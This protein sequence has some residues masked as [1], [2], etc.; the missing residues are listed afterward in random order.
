ML[1][2]SKQLL[3]LTQS[4]HLRPDALARRQLILGKLGKIEA[5]AGQICIH[6]AEGIAV[7][8][9]ELL[10]LND[11][12]VKIPPSTQ[13]HAVQNLARFLERCLAKLSG[14]LVLFREGRPHERCHLGG[15]LPIQLL[16]RV[17]NA[18]LAVNRRHD[19]AQ[20]RAFP[21]QKLRH[22]GA[23]RCLQASGTRACASRILHGDGEVLRAQVCSCG[24]G[25]ADSQDGEAQ[26]DADH[27]HCFTCL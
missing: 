6:L 4:L 1:C 8:L 2:L 3:V 14:R 26:L 13:D 23:Q 27:L 12:I 9:T 5:D 24:D 20:R 25:H 16:H 18:H 10:A 21:L 7:L 22:H 17:D 11:D 15:Q 19:V